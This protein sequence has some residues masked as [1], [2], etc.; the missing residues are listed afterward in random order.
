MRAGK[1]IIADKESIDETEVYFEAR[2]KS[3]YKNGIE[4]LYG[5]YNRCIALEVTILNN[6]VKFYRK[7]VFF[8]DT[9]RTFLLPCYRQ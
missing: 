2:D 1:R 9:L 8:Y 4:N 7:N 3:F 6:K 5:S